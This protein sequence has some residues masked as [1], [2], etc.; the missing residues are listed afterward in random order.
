MTLVRGEP[1]LLNLAGSGTGP[2]KDELP[3]LAALAGQIAIVVVASGRDPQD[4]TRRFG[5]LPFPVVVDPPWVIPMTRSARSR[6]RG[7]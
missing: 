6:G 2:A 1:V 7:A 5:K 4:V 3:E